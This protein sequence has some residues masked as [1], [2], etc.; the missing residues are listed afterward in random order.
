MRSRRLPN[1]TLITVLDTA[2]APG[3]ACGAVIVLPTGE[4]IEGEPQ[5]DFDPAGRPIYDPAQIAT[6]VELGY[7]ADVLAMTRDHDAMHALLSDWLGLPASLALEVAAGRRSDDDLSR[8]EEAAVLAV[9]AY[10]R[11]AGGRLPL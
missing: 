10:M 7:G 4:R 9:M 2:P 6:A 5:G 11:R 1:G 8:L 3:R